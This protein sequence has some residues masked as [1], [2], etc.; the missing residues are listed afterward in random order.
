MTKEHENETETYPCKNTTYIFTYNYIAL[1]T[2]N[3]IRRDNSHC[4]KQLEHDA[5]FQILLYR[6]RANILNDCFKVS[7]QRYD[8]NEIIQEMF[9]RA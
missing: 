1:Q 4:M 7:T 6:F 9:F 2:P 3:W 8:A 5:V